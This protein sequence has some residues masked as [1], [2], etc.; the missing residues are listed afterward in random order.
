MSIEY[1]L[2]IDAAARSFSSHRVYAKFTTSDHVASVCSSSYLEL[3]RHGAYPLDH[4]RP[5]V[6]KRR[7]ADSL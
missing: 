7:L 2:Y 4:N 6:M 3:A 1:A 5:P